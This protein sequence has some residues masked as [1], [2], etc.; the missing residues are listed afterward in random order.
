[1]QPDWNL[2]LRGLILVSAGACLLAAILG[3]WVWRQV[4]RLQ[5]PA[6]ASFWQTLRLT[7]LSVVLL[8]DLL[9]MGLDIFSAPI[10]WVLLERM[11]LRSLRMVTVS[12]AILPGTQFLPIMTLAWLAARTFRRLPPLA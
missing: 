4:Q 7:P 12:E 11:G 2:I 10:T 8:L 1:M 9:D 5:V 3:I 6:H